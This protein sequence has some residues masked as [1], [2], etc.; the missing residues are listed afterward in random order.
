MFYGLPQSVPQGGAA[1][2]L[3]FENALARLERFNV[4]PAVVVP[5]IPEDFYEN[6]IL[7]FMLGSITAEQAA[8]EI[9]NRISLWLI[10]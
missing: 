4:K 3:Y 5:Y 6:T 7:E 9:H 10:E 2:R 8:A 1:R